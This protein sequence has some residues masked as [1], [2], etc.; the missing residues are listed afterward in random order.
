V[1]EFALRL[2]EQQLELELSDSDLL[3]L[4]VAGK[5]SISVATL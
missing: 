3:V 2:A 4:E 5:R 1:Q